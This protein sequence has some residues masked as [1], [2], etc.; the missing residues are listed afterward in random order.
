MRE[1][2]TQSR[3]ASSEYRELLVMGLLSTGDPG[4]RKEIRDYYEDGENSGRLEFPSMLNI[5]EDPWIEEY[6]WEL[7]RTPDKHI[8]DEKYLYPVQ[9]N[10]LGTAIWHIAEKQNFPVKARW[11]QACV[12]VETGPLRKSM[13]LDEDCAKLAYF[14]IGEKQNRKWLDDKGWT[15]RT[16]SQWLAAHPN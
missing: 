12:T 3:Y 7:W 4:M 1:L 16:L 14:L 9:T 10:A 13:S 6:L 8:N 5:H 2:K 11:V 15:A